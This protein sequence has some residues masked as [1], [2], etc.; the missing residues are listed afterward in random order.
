MGEMMRT[1][2]SACLAM[3]FVS[4][5]AFGAD[6]C[7]Q[8]EGCTRFTGVGL[9]AVHA[10]DESSFNQRQLLAIRAAKLDA[11]RSLAEQ[12]KGLRL[13]AQSATVATDL[14]NDRVDISIDTTLSGVR[15]VKVAAIQPGIYQAIAEMDVYQH[16]APPSNTGKSQ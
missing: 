12:A 8:A 16:D 11:L 7:W 6:Y 14:V 4:L 5:N 1:R 13:Q 2:L 3:T 15:Y 9:A 10:G